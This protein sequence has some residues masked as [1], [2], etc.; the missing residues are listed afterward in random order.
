MLIKT[1]ELNIK[2]GRKYK[3]INH[4]IHLDSF[5]FHFKSHFH[6]H[7]SCIPHQRYII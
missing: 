2:W 3:L 4:T 5:S 1:S 6:F 7:A